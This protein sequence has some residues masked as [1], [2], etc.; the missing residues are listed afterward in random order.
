MFMSKKP[1]KSRKEAREMPMHRKAKT[2]AGHLNE[3]LRKE[4]GKR[5]LPLR[6][7]DVVKIIRGAFKGK[8]GKINRVDRKNKKIFI[9]KIMKKKSDGTEFEV[10]IDASKI[11]VTE[12]DKSDRKRLKQIKKK[13]DKK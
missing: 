4:I 1:R 10:A 2:I 11:I 8:E 13:S 5:A 6:K 3:K 12:I 9:E 7:G